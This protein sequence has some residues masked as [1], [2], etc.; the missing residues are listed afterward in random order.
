MYDVPAEQL[1]LM[2]S[3]E[4][5]VVFEDYTIPL[6]SMGDGTRAAMRALMCLAMIEKTLFLMEEPECHQHPAA[7]EAFAK[8]MCAIAKKREIQIILTTHSMECIR[9]FRKATQ[10]SESTFAVHHLSLNDGVQKARRLDGD[11]F[12]SLDEGG[13]DVRYA[14]LYV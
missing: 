13:L 11:A 9:A 7:L 12:D 10:E 5:V 14:D 3:G 1:Q 2:P 6:D 4:I 8:G